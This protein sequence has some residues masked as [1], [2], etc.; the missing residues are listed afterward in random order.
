MEFCGMFIPLIGLW[1]VLWSLRLAPKR[2]SINEVLFLDGELIE[3]VVRRKQQEKYNSQHTS[4]LELAYSKNSQH[5]KWVV[6]V[7]YEQGKIDDEGNY[8][9]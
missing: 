6:R 4:I 7:W 8:K 1:L 3:D 2:P 9:P 5:P